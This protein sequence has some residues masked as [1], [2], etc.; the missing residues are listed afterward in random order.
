MTQKYARS[1]NHALAEQY[2][3][4]FLFSEA[5]CGD[6]N[7]GENRTC[8]SLQFVGDRKLFLHDAGVVRAA[9]IHISSTVTK[10]ANA[11]GAD[12]LVVG[13]VVCLKCLDNFAH[14]FTVK[15]RFSLPCP[16]V[17]TCFAAPALLRKKSYAEVQ[18]NEF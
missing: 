3:G 10:A 11:H 15:S 4:D 16:H 18:R 8:R 2:A 1:L 13:G 14:T 17:L 9:F 7:D 12:I 5:S 6:R